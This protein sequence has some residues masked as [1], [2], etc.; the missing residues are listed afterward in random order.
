MSIWTRVANV[1]R[2]SKVNREIDEELQAHMEDAQ[3]DGRDAADARRALGSPLKHRDE[4]HDARVVVWLDSLRADAVYG[5]RRLAR[6]KVTTAAAILSLGLAIGACTAAFRLVDAVMLAPLPVKAP[7]ELYSIARKGVDPEGKPQLS[8]LWEYPL[9]LKMREGLKGDA[10]LVASTGGGSKDVTYSTADAMEKARWGYVSGWMFDSFALKPAAGRLLNARDD[11]GPSARPV[12]VLSERYWARRFG[13]DPGV[14]GTTV[15]LDDKPY[16]IVGVVAAPF[17][18]MSPGVMTDVFAPM[19]TSGFATNPTVNWFRMFVRVPEGRSPERVRAELDPIVYATRD[20]EIKNNSQ[21]MTEQQKRDL[22]NQ[23]L[24]MAPAATGVSHF[25]N[26]NRDALLALS[27]LVS[28]VLLIACAN[29]ANLVMAQAASRERELALRV[30]IGGGRR[31]LVQL[32]LVESAWIGV[33]ASVL[34]AVFAWW[35]APF[36]IALNSTPDNPVQLALPADWRVLGFALALTFVVTL[37][38]GLAPALRASKVDPSSA[39]KG[40]EDPHARRRTMNLLIAA[41]VA[42]CFLV[43]FVSGMFVATF[44]RLSHKPT[45]FSAER[46]L[47]LDTTSDKRH[48]ADEWDAL[49]AQVQQ[50]PGVERAAVAGWPLMNEMAWTDLIAFNGGPPNETVSYFIPASTQW[51][52]TMKIPIVE[53]RAVRPG[54]EG[55]GEAVV[56]REFVKAYFHGADP[57]GK[58]FENAGDSDHRVPYQVV[59]VTGDICYGDLHECALPVAYLS[60]YADGPLNH[61]GIQD[62][63]LIVRTV[64]QDP[65]SMAETLRQAV[66][67]AHMGFRV[68]NVRTQQSINDV[69]TM[70][71]RMLAILALFFAVVALVLAGVGLYGVMNYSVVQRRRE[72]GIRMAV[73]AGS[74]DIARSVVAATAAMVCAGAVVG[75]GVGL[76]AARSFAALLYDGKPTDL[77][78]LALPAAAILCAAVVAALPAVVRAVRIDPVILLRSE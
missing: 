66:A 77:G 3:A 22:M 18:G 17:T 37:L 4:A 63:T 49:V 64:A 30:S 35:A 46:V 36:V 70:R 44:A 24:V 33:M 9:F 43:V 51:L 31:R 21:G 56:S 7:Q 28:L 71:E 54:A 55:K 39:L 60:F 74:A 48:H 76:V 41:Q 61:G 34:G 45:G 15:K 25:R 57:V 72:I 73:G 29:V 75:V 5:W 59:G 65:S 10:E 16:E 52:E 13:R 68:T 50:V 69:Q 6:S 32:V 14:I 8:E 19:S 26:E 67:D 40:G 53:G 1:F 12:V 62:G 47:A 38:F 11:S 78:A 42:F 20:D 58:I 2:S 23:T 27:A